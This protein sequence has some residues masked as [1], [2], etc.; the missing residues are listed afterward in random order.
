MSETLEMIEPEESDP[1][2]VKVPA[3]TKLSLYLVAGLSQ[4]ASFIGRTFIGLYAVFIG[5]TASALSLITS[6]REL[7]QQVFQFTFGR[8]SDRI[9]RKIM[10]F[11]GLIGT[12]V[13]IAL[14]PLIQNGW[15][16][17]G[18]V[19]IFS[20]SFSI[21]Y[22][23]FAAIQGDLTNRKNRAGFISFITII[24][25]F[26][27]LIGLLVVGFAS[28]IGNTERAQY[29][30]IL[31]ITAGIFLISAIVTLLLHDPP[32]EMLKEK[33]P[34]SFDP[35]RKNRTFRRF[36][37][38]NSIM[39]FAMSIGWPIFPIVRGNFASAKENTWIWAV[40]AIFQIITL[41]GTYKIVNKI[42]R[43]WLVYLGRVLM[44]YVPLNM[45]LTILYWPTWWHMA[46]AGAIS[47]ACNSLYLV[48]QNTYILDCA[49]EKEKGT[50][51]GVHNLFIGLSTFIG[52]LIMGIIADAL[53]AHF[54][55]WTIIIILN[56]VI[57]G[58]RFIAGFGFFLIKEPKHMHT[59]EESPIITTE[60]ESDLVE[61]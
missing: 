43:K 1:N 58:V 25:A 15:V 3:S 54:D 8:I 19:A 23:A 26:A 24:G 16:L 40:F 9:G 12:A 34:F 27:T 38:I 28:D 10:M 53:I 29:I 45:A 41:F 20:I 37:L 39:S 44:F 5:S 6:L 17:V 49:G 33:Q 11:I 2:H 35:I 21:Y 47:G 30:I 7:I 48:G 46:I 22:P 51:T 32:R 13:S 36:V 50:Y 60:E 4:C 56:L 55:E 31:E 42:K 14:F 52:S 18:G 61:G 59:V 57:S